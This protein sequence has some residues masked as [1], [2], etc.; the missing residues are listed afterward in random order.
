MLRQKPPS[1]RLPEQYFPARQLRQLHH[2]LQVLSEEHR[3]PEHCPCAPKGTRTT[4]ASRQEPTAPNPVIAAGRRKG[5]PY[6][7]R[8]GSRSRA[9]YASFDADTTASVHR[10]RQRPLRLPRHARGAIPIPHPSAQHPRRAPASSTPCGPRKTP[11]GAPRGLPA[12]VNLVRR[13]RGFAIGITCPWPTEK[14]DL[15]LR[16]NRLS[17]SQWMSSV[18]PGSFVVPRLCA[19][20]RV[21]RGGTPS[22]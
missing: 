7:L 19:G 22:R 3:P 5:W 20:H 15:V 12:E 14:G 11:L 10:A 1:E 16:L 4:R 9:V 6:W 13:A 8:S 2:V 18:H 17:I 21:T